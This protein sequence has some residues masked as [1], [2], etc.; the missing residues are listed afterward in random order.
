MFDQYERAYLPDK[1][2]SVEIDLEGRQKVEFVSLLARMLLGESAD[3]KG[4]VALDTAKS[5]AD[6]LFDEMLED[7]VNFCN[8]SLPTS[9]KTLP[10]LSPS[11][12]SLETKPKTQTST[13]SE[14]SETMRSHLKDFF[15]AKSRKQRCL[16]ISAVINTIMVE[17]DGHLFG[18]LPCLNDYHR[19][20]VI[21]NDP[22]VIESMQLRKDSPAAKRKPDN[23]IVQLSHLLKL[24]DMCKDSDYR[25][26]VQLVETESEKCKWA[27][28]GTDK[29]TSWLDVHCS[30]ELDALRVIESALLDQPMS[31]D[32]V[33]G[34]TSSTPTSDV[35]QSS[36]TKSEVKR[37]LA[38]QPSSSS[39]GAASSRS[40]EKKRNHADVEESQTETTSSHKKRKTSDPDPPRF[41]A[42]IQCAYYAI[43]HL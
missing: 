19:I 40:C 24:D 14:T 23:I 16:P 27:Q 38:S 22:L 29:K 26:W 10:E 15:Q 28:K 8:S 41:P 21:P 34:G 12:I 11:E 31:K 37:Q 36:D 25:S 9:A 20:I 33:L 39:T 2:R 17:Y 1:V 30:I 42:E 7:A 32:Q 4:T 18:R 13:R 35:L 6:Q 5:D 3:G 43:E